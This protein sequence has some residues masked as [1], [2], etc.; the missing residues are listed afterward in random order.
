MKNT[1]CKQL[2]IISYTKMFVTH[3][4][5]EVPQ[6]YKNN[7]DQEGK[8]HEGLMPFSCNKWSIAM[9]LLGVPRVRHKMCGS[10]CHT[11]RKT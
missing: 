2:F 7:E 6:N 10:L 8:D 9:F 3:N 1:K 5:L 4:K 11:S